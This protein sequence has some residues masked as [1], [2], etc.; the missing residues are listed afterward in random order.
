MFGE[1]AIY[2]EVKEKFDAI[3][4]QFCV[5]RLR[6]SAFLGQQSM[7]PA[8]GDGSDISLLGSCPFHYSNCLWLSVFHNED[9][10]GQILFE[11]TTLYSSM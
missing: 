7:L 3:H 11:F 10:D 8:M 6:N 1:F 5:K 4:R 2:C 9:S